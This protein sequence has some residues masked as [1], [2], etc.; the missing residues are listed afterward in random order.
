MKINLVKI[1]ITIY[2][3]NIEIM[4]MDMILMNITQ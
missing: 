4:I 2:L 3:K 1:R